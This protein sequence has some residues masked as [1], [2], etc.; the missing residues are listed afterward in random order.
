MSKESKATPWEIV[1]MARD[2]SLLY[3]CFK[4]P[5]GLAKALGFPVRFVNANVNVFKAR[6]FQFQNM[7]VPEIVINANMSDLS[8]RF[9]C[10]HEI[11]HAV[12]HAGE[13]TYDVTRKNK[14]TDVEY[15]ANL[16]AIGFMFPLDNVFDKP[17]CE[18]SS[19]ELHRI[20]EDNIF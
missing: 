20:I 1:G 2:W 19:F 3:H 12:L 7:P 8:K 10:A 18:M 14:D 13:N 6:V 9:L 5:F 17:V 15:E 4:D 16:F 11:G